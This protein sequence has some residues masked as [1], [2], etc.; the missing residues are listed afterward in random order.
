EQTVVVPGA[1]AASIVLPR[2]AQQLVALRRQREDVAKEVERLVV[3][4]PLYPVLTSMPGV[5]VRTAARLLTDVASRA[6]AS[7]AHLAA[8]AGLA[9]ATRRSGSSLRGQHP[10][11]RGNKQLKRAMFLSPFASLR[12]PASRAYYARKINAGKRHNPALIALAR[13]R[14]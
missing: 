10:S 4:H 1:N 12:D 5:G 9:L 3:A 8:Y 6:L 2:L 11:S 14:C 7:A 13:R